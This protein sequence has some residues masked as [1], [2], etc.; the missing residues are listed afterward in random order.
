LQGHSK[1]EDEQAQDGGGAAPRVGA[2]RGGD[3]GRA[4]LSA[5]AIGKV[6]T[7]ALLDA[8]LAVA[9]RRRRLRCRKLPLRFMLL[10]CMLIYLSADEALP[11]VFLHL[12]GRWAGSATRLLVSASALCQVRYCLGV[13]PVEAL[14]RRVCQPLATAQMPGAFLFGRRLFAVDSTKLDVPD[15]PANVAAFGRHH[16]WRGTSAWP[17]V[18]LVL[19]VE[20]G[21]HAVCDAGVWPCNMDEGRA[22][23]RLLRSVGPRALVL[24]DRGFQSVEMMEAT[25]GCSAD[26]LGRLP[27]TVRPLPLRQLADGTSLVAL[28]PGWMR[29]RRRGDQ[30]VAR[31]I[32]YTLDDPRRPGHWIEHR[33]VTTL[34]DPTAA[35]ARKLILAYHQRWENELVVD[36]LKTHQGPARPCRSQRPVGVLQEIYSLLIAHYLLRALAVTAA[37]SAQVAPTRVSFVA[38]LR[39]LR[40]HVVRG[41]WYRSPCRCVGWHLSATLST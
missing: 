28:R 40:D 30:V 17:Q 21:T 37:H 25:T 2:E 41:D 27:A 38:A 29:H 16:A 24:W 22:G 23:R 20:C 13:R 10:F 14:F 8:A 18:R 35:P 12:A 6:L 36:E 11:A 3:V 15:S 34:L 33:L 1:F 5:S 19:L 4:A 39:L 9:S 32:R 7:S 31:L 26:F